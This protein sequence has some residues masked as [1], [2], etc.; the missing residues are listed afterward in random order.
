MKLQSIVRKLLAALII[1]AVPESTIA[2]LP[3][4][5]SELRQMVDYAQL[6]KRVY[7]VKKEADGGQV[8]GW[9]ILDSGSNPDS[10]LE[11]AVYERTTTTGKRERVLAFGGTD[12][13]WKELP[14]SVDQALFGTIA[15]FAF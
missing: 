6:S 5:Y 2:Q 3:N 1:F 4:S 15:D 9:M 13:W 10:G 7:E 12:D 14:Q 8:P 11:W